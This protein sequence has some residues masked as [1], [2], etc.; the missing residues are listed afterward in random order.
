MTGGVDLRAANVQLVL[1]VG[2]GV[3]LVVEPQVKALTFRHEWVTVFLGVLGPQESRRALALISIARVLNERVT[4][5]IAP[6]EARRRLALMIAGLV[7][8]AVRV[9]LVVGGEQ[10]HGVITHLARPIT[11]VTEVVFPSLEALA[12]KWIRF[13]VRRRFGDVLGRG[14]V[15]YRLLTLFIVVL[16]HLVHFDVRLLVEDEAVDHG[17]GVPG[18]LLDDIVASLFSD[19]ENCFIR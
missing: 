5:L 15:R 8:V 6:Y 17:L 4:L 9:V 14:I 2:I 11:L 16:D 10:A 19:F 18:G 7:L 3:D 12:L 1:R 13:A